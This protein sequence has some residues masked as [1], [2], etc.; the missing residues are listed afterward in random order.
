MLVLLAVAQAVQADTKTWTGAVDGLWSNPGNWAGGVPVA[1]DRLSF[2]NAPGTRATVNDLAPGTVFQDLTFLDG[3]YTLS[4]NGIG[5]TGGISGAEALNLPI[6]LQASQTFTNVTL[7]GSVDLQSYTLTLRGGSTTATGVISGSGVVVIPSGSGFNFLGTHT[8]S[9]PTLVTGFLQLNGNLVSS[10]VTV[11]L[12]VGSGTLYSLTSPGG[13]ITPYGILN[14]GNLDLGSTRLEIDLA[15]TTAGVDYAQLNVTGTV[16]LNNTNLAVSLSFSPLVGQ[17]FVL[18]NNDGGDA[19]VGTFSGRPEGSTI[20]L[21]ASQFRVSYAG[22][23]GNDVTLTCTFTPKTW[24]GAVN[25]LWSEAGNWAGGV[26]PLPGD[27]LSFPAGAANQSNTNDL[28][29]GTTYAQLLMTGGPYTLGGNGIG[30]TG[31]ISGGTVNLPIQLRASQSFINVT[32]G[33]SVDLQSYTLTLSGGSTTAAGVISG[34]GGVVIPSGSGFNFLGT[35]TYSGATLVTGFLQLNGNLVSSPVTVGLLVGSGTLY[36]LTSPGGQITPYGILNSGNLNLGSTRLE[37][38]LAGTTAGVGY[39]QLK[40]TGT[41]TL[42]NTNLAVSLSFS[43]SVGQTFVLVNNDGVGPVAGTFSGKPEGSIITLNAIELRLSYAGGDGNDVVL[44]CTVVPKSW[45]GAVNALWSN[46]GNWSGG[47]LPAPGDLLVFP[48]GASNFNNTNDLAPGTTYA[49]LLFTGGPYTLDGNAIGLTGGASGGG[50]LNLPIR[51]QAS[52]SFAGSFTLDGSVDLQSYTLTL[53]GG[54][55]TATS[56]ISGSG[57]VV[58]PSG[59][60]F[61]FGGTHT[62]SGPT[63]ASGF[64]Q[65]NG[66]LVSSPLTT[67]GLFVGS[68][69]VY[70]LTTSG[71][72]VEPYGILNT[73]NLNLASRLEIFLAGPTA[74]VNYAQFNVTGTVALGDRFLALSLGFVPAQGQ[75]FVLVNNDGTDATSGTFSGLPEGSIVNLGPYPFVLSYAGDTG[76]DV[77]LTSQSGDP[78]NHAPVAVDDSY[79]AY[80]DTPLVVG[81]PGVLQF[82]SDVD[83]N[84]LTVLQSSP[85]SAHGGTVVV[86]AN[87]GFTY[88]PPASYVGPDSFTY[89][90]S[91]GHNATDAGTVNI[92]VLPAPTATPSLT[93]TITSTPTLSPTASVTP[94]P[95]ATISPTFP[96]VCGDGV[97]ELG[98]QCDDGNVVSGDICPSAP[99]DACRF[100]SKLIRGNRRA[101]RRNLHGC[102][103]E[104]YV[105]NPNQGLDRY[106][107]PS[108][109][110]ECRDQDAACDFD[111]QP[112]RCR[113]KVVTC[114]NTTDANLPACAAQGVSRIRVYRPSPRVTR[115]TAFQTVLAADRVAFDTALQHLL[116]PNDP[117]PGYA[118][119]I[120]IIPAEQNQCSQ[121]TDID[122]PLLGRRLR[123]MSLLV[124][125]RDA[126]TPRSRVALS[127]LRLTCRQ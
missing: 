36:S 19:V 88:T 40:A 103:I 115:L 74:G 118:N 43:P 75:A 82:D 78:L 46:P 15:G 123:S 57:G 98:E 71:G 69:T 100:T 114:L 53:S 12:L 120:P 91:D 126:A 117:G 85:T 41:V 23:D 10:P 99:G 107:L 13:Q 30:L 113:F 58:I 63:L 61:N 92:T 111:P 26:P 125:T 79:I 95:S 68:G 27:I 72:S 11:G 101:P 62:Y 33:G 97:L 108:N 60:S 70:S 28:P 32:L 66:N 8:Y 77:T 7:A 31:G 9:G 54:S 96:P 84:T 76:N 48:S 1:G 110:Q 55:T 20:T 80:S 39:G 81:P 73:G 83:M 24:T 14:S 109:R 22:G 64:L 35:H 42:N 67:M 52:Q 50:T 122:V 65:L 87:G 90:V 16:K 59:S 47:V 17:T 89:V 34:S 38:D 29:P 51:L 37:I 102:Q 2:F 121:A 124:R 127:R 3:G 18:V 21:G 86:N 4:G 105:A 116:D 104:W 93:P 49:Q 25:N 94:T 112:G 45:T 119:Q 56:V 6:Q 44:T 106:G 5:L